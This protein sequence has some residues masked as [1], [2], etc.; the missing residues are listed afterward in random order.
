MHARD[1]EGENTKS[2]DQYQEL[3]ERI[4][5][6]CEDIIVNFTTGGGIFSRKECITRTVSTE[7]YNGHLFIDSAA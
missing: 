1:E 4:D 2:T 7:S 3:R 5:D 6:R